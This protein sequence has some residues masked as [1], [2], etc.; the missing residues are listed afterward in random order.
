MNIFPAIDLINGKCV[1][2]EKGDFNKTT[3][4]QLE[5]KD[6]A[7]SYQQAGAKFIHVV[8]LDG[9]KKGQTCQ[10]E[11]IQQIRDN[12][13]MTLQVGGGIKDFATIDKLLEI[14]V[15]RVVIGSLAVKDIELT[16]K[17]FEKYGAEKIVLALDVF[18]KEGTPYIATHGWQES[19]TITLDQIIQTYLADGLEY[20]LCTDISRDGM[21][22]GPNFELYRVYSSIYPDIKFMASGGV[23]KLEDLKI[24]K[25]QDAYGVII[26][27][28]L[29]ENKFT[30]QEALE[31]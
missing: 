7:N 3:T 1:R 14:G 6:V 23:G 31:C 19:S 10:F 29:Y 30:L 13:N 28:A 12:C 5:P 4:Y 15:D 20:V 9:A 2:L 17:F 16:K 27:K 22:Q 25:E 26:G 11:T 18:I 21:L 24:L 8:D